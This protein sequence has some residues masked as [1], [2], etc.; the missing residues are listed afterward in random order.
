MRAPL[1]L[2]HRFRG[3]VVSVQLILACSLLHVGWMWALCGTEVLTFRLA[4]TPQKEPWHKPYPR[5][6]PLKGTEK[7]SAV[8]PRDPAGVSSCGGISKVF[9]YGQHGQL[10]FLPAVP[11]T[12]KGEAWGNEFLRFRMC[13]H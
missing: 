9:P 3:A 1:R 7:Q 12:G 10:F 13:C 8:G 4:I 5:T 2:L 6:L 11:D